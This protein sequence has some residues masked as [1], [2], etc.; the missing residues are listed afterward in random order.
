MG[1]RLLKSGVDN[2]FGTQ[3]R[4]FL[5][6]G[7]RNRWTA[8]GSGLMTTVALQSS[9]AM[10][11]MVSSFVAQGLIAPAMAQ[12]VMLGANVGTSIVAQLLALDV[13]W[14]ASAL[15]M[16]GIFLIGRR[17]NR[18]RDIGEAFIGLGLMLLSLW[19][20]GEVTEPIHESAVVAAFFALITDAPVIAIAMV[21]AMAAASASSLAVVLFVMTLA[22]TGSID[23]GLAL[24]LVAGANLG[25]A[26]PPVIAV[27]AEGNEVRRIAISNLSVR[28]AGSVF[29]MLSVGWI[30]PLVGPLT[31]LVEHLML[32]QPVQQENTPRHLDEAALQDEPAALAAATRETLR[33]GDIVQQMLEANL[34]ALRSNDELLCRSIF[35]LNDSV[36]ALQEAVELYLSRLDRNRL[37]A[38]GRRHANAIL[39]YAVN[40]EHVGDIIERSLSGLA[41]IEDL[42]YETIDNLQLAQGVFLSRD[43][44]MARRLMESKVLIRRKERDAFDRHMDRLRE[45]RVATLQTTRLHIDILRDLKRINSHLVIAAHPILQEAGMLRESRLK[46]ERK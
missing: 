31:R 30:V 34:G 19:L 6:S 40:L 2:A 24:L 8:F 13:H 39:D 3:L 16:S 28:S 37:S 9:T 17:K 25:G 27:A 45:K 26:V 35:R 14:L 22:G 42:F 5:A 23:A 4:L 43:A 1:L 15:V 12:A 38:E 33:I 11:I 21:A 10:A 20:M 36:D 32:D 7:T 44:H 41:K 29:M 46:R 18:T